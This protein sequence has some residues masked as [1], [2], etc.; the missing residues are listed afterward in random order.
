M[1][2]AYRKQKLNSTSV[3]GFSNRGVK[4][5]KPVIIK[6][7]GCQSNLGDCKGILQTKIR[8][9]MSMQQMKKRLKSGELTVGA[10]HDPQP[11]GY[12]QA[13]HWKTLHGQRQKHK[14]LQS[15]YNAKGNQARLAAKRNSKVSRGDSTLMQQPVTL[16]SSKRT[17]VDQDGVQ[18]VMFPPFGP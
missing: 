9:M 17:I 4:K 13:Y 1:Y 14:T 12:K 5:Q 2:S 15:H 10:L 3:S 16:A 11:A 7:T 6:N 18:P 8:K